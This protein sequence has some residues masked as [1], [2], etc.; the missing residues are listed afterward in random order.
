MTYE[1][2]GDV[3]LDMLSNPIS[4]MMSGCP[5]PDGIVRLAT[6]YKN[7]LPQDKRQVVA[8]FISEV[9]TF[10]Y[11]DKYKCIH[12]FRDEFARIH[13]AIIKDFK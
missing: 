5:F 9:T 10:G 3:I 6:E 11:N 2:I 4:A 8:D 7:R 12:D 1:M 13:A